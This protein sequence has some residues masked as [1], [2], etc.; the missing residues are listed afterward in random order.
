M[1]SRS[2]LYRFSLTVG[3]NAPEPRAYRA[4]RLC[5]YFARRVET[6]LPND[7][8]LA[9]KGKRKSFD[10]APRGLSLRMKT[11]MAARHLRQL[12]VERRVAITE[13]ENEGPDAQDG[14]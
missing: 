9:V 13:Q 8:I 12:F 10:S 11:R 4:T 2:S 14:S 6:T 5:F 3:N 1:C 7:P